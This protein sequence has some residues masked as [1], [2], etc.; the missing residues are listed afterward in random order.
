MNAGWVTF[1]SSAQFEFKLP[2]LI[3][4]I[5]SLRQNIRNQSINETNSGM[6]V[7]QTRNK[8]NKINVT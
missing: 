8:W 1:E 6:A 2:L 7:N 3:D 4:F 5:A